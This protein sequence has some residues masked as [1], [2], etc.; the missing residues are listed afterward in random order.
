MDDEKALYAFEHNS[1]VEEDRRKPFIMRTGRDRMDECSAYNNVRTKLL[2][3][4]CKKLKELA[5]CYGRS[6]YIAH[7]NYGELQVVALEDI[8]HYFY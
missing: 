1:Q 2:T 6:D 5:L 7:F 4:K 8:H 3:I